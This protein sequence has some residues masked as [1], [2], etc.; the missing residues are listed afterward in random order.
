MGIR[1]YRPMTPGTRQRSGADF[2]EITKDKPEKKLTKYNHRKVGRNNEGKITSRFRGGGHKRL[3]RT[4]DFKRDKRGTAATVLAIEYDPNR[5]ARIA[6][7]QYTD[8]EKRY[9]LHP[10]NLKVG[11]TIS[12]GDDALIEIG[13]AL[14]LEKIPLGSNVHNVE[15]LPGRGGQMARSAGAVVQLVAKEGAYA[16]LKLPSGEVRQVLKGCYATIG[17]V[18]N[19][20]AKNIS[21][22]KAGRNRWLGKRPHNRGVVMNAV[23]HPHGGGEGK[24]PIGGKPQTPWGKSALGTKTRKK[25]KP[26]SKFIIRRR[27]SVSG[28]G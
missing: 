24:S 6:L 25:R 19:I 16:T 15:L 4:I 14:P 21:I 17:Q 20:D 26:S 27:K 9:I 8:G 22:G 12:A 2:A 7:V 13:C 10:V 18:G 3:Y 1:K 28:R 23:D 5:N 11:A